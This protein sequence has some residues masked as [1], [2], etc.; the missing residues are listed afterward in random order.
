MKKPVLLLLVAFTFCF[1]A[2]A[3]HITTDRV[4]GQVGKAFR[5]KFP[6]AQ[7]DS[8]SMEDGHTYEVDFFNG[9]KKQSATFDETGKWLETETEIGINQAPV[10]VAK[11]YMKQFTGFNI[12]DVYQQEKPDSTSYEITIIKTHQSYELLYSAKGEL[13]KKAPIR[14][15]KE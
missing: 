12:Q 2:T 5:A 3:Q 1:V 7:Q 13:L 15:E 14:G 9:K 10:A 8:W 4:P 6:A 11:A